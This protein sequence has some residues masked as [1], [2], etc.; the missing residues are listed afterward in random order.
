MLNITIVLDSSESKCK[1]HIRLFL[2]NVWNAFNKTTKASKPLLIHKT[3]I[4]IQ[5]FSTDRGEAQMKECA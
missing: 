2:L 5:S 1:L 3:T 4:K